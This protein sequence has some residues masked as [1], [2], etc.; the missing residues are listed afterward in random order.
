MLIDIR[1]LYSTLQ[2]RRTLKNRIT[3]S[4]LRICGDNGLDVVGLEINE[5]LEEVLAP[6]LLPID[7][8]RSFY[9]K[10]ERIYSKIVNEGDL[11]YI[12]NPYKIGDDESNHN[13]DLDG[14]IQILNTDK[15]NINNSVSLKVM[16]L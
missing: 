15:V 11:S 6:F 10:V 13:Y 3:G 4:I 8:T 5:L 12:L 16:K 2:Y 7:D 9:R 1:N 14:D